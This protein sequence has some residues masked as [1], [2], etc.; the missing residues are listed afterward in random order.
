MA[1]CPPIID[2][3]RFETSQ[4]GWVYHYRCGRRSS[5]MDNYY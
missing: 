4:R 1:D 5:R 3:G 2:H